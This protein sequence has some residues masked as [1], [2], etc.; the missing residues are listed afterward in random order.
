M[1]TIWGGKGGFSKICYVYNISVLLSG[2]EEEDKA[3]FSCCFSTVFS[4]K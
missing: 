2:D 3:L 4:A 1:G